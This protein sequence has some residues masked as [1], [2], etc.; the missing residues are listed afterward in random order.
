MLNFKSHEI[1]VFLKKKEPKQWCGVT[2]LYCTHCADRCPTQWVQSSNVVPQ[3]CL[4]SFRD[5]HQNLVRSSTLY[6]LNLTCFRGLGTDY[7]VCY[8]DTTWNRK[9]C[10]R[11]MC[12]WRGTFLEAVEA[13]ERLVRGKRWCTGA[14]GCHMDGILAITGRL[15]MNR[16]DWG[17]ESIQARLP[18]SRWVCFLYK[19]PLHLACIIILPHLPEVEGCWPA[20]AAGRVKL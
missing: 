19:W 4:T 3:H 11:S 17:L 15:M 12:K 2:K 5:K 10:A 9:L 16:V 13:M 14:V 1:V 8:G 20:A 7:K 18:K 6:H